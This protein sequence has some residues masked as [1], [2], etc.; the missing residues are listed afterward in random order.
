MRTTLWRWLKKGWEWVEPWLLIGFTIAL[1]GDLLHGRCTFVRC[2]FLALC[3]NSLRRLIER[4]LIGVINQALFDQ[5]RLE[6]V[7]AAT[8]AETKPKV[9]KALRVTEEGGGHD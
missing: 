8:W 4:W 3:L 5:K 6:A 1:L 2:V 9:L 7:W